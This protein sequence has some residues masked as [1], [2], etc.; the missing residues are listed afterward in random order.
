MVQP[1]ARTFIKTSVEFRPA[2][3][4]LRLPASEYTARMRAIVEADALGGSGQRFLKRS[5]DSVMDQAQA[6][7]QTL[8]KY[9]M[10][11]LMRTVFVP[12]DKIEEA[13]ERVTAGLADDALC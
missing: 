13:Y 3:K 6:F 11:T 1:E 9:G 4:I 8:E 5:L 2:A 10:R 12:A 7:E